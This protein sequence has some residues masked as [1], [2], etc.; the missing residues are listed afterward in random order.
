M[1]VVAGYLLWSEILPDGPRAITAMEQ[2]LRRQMGTVGRMI[3]SVV[4][5]VPSFAS[6]TYPVVRGDESPGESTA[7]EDGAAAEGDG[8][9]L[10]GA[11]AAAPEGE[12]DASEPGGV[13]SPES[14]GVGDTEEQT[15]PPAGGPGEGEVAPFVADWSEGPAGNLA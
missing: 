13:A 1:G 15:G 4:E 14:Q 5:E 12:P 2:L 3:V 7:L 10:V 9:V 8:Q 6:L 11:P